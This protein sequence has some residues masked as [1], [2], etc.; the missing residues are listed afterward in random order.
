MYNSLQHKMNKLFQRANSLKDEVQTEYEDER[1]K[2]QHI[3]KYL[4]LATDSKVLDSLI[5]D[6]Y[7]ADDI[8]DSEMFELVTDYDDL[9]KEVDQIKYILNGCK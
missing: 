4:N 8:D 6:H 1:L 7:M 9:E 2:D 3:T 5:N